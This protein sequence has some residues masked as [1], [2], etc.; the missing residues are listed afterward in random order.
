M[1]FYDYG[2]KVFDLI[3]LSR[4]LISLQHSICELHVCYCLDNYFLCAM[5]QFLLSP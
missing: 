1:A 2:F 3:T 5:V 4:T